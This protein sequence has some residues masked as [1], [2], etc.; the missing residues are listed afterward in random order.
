MATAKKAKVKKNLKQ[1]NHK[2]SPSVAPGFEASAAKHL[3]QEAVKSTLCSGSPSR[4]IV[5]SLAFLRR[6]DLANISGKYKGI[7]FLF[8]IF[9]VF[10]G[11]V[12]QNYGEKSVSYNNRLKKHNRPLMC[13]SLIWGLMTRNFTQIQAGLQFQEF[14]IF[15]STSFLTVEP[16][17]F[18]LKSDPTRVT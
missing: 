18:D 12:T 8:L 15:Q 2:N 13:G 3:G 16:D 10:G 17:S 11:K 5:M 7:C 9:F 1:K 4:N 6:S 14:F